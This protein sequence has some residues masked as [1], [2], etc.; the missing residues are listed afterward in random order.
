MEAYRTAEGPLRS[1]STEA[2]DKVHAEVDLKMRELEET[3]LSR[4]ELLYDKTTPGGVLPLV[5][6]PV[7]QFLKRNRLAR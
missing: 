3:G 1:M 7:F 5:E 4:T 2:I 6:D